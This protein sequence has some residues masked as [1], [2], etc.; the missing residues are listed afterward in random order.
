MSKY[1]NSLA[2]KPPM[3]N[4]LYRQSI[5]LGIGLVAAILAF[6]LPRTIYLWLSG[7]GVIAILVTVLFFT[8]EVRWILAIVEREHAAFKGKGALF[9]MLGIFLTALLF[10]EQA[11]VSILVLAIADAAATVGGTLFVSPKLPYNHRKT[12]FGSGV[13]FLSATLVLAIAHPVVG[14][15]FIAFLLTALESFDYR[16]IPFLDDNLVIPL[17]TAS[18][19][20]YL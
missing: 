11:G 6:I 16:E 7:L 4:E 3:A 15:V 18:L 17:V 13:F 20:A 9:F 14:V 5:H 2:L 8:R 19:L 1:L 12:Y 10:W